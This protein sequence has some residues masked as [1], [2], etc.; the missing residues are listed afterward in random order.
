MKKSPDHMDDGSVG[1]TVTKSRA[2]DAAV[3]LDLLCQLDDPA[4][5]KM[6]RDM[7]AERGIAGKV[8]AMLFPHLRRVK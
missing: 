4:T 8:K 2:R 7:L 3:A 1:P 5:W 6:T